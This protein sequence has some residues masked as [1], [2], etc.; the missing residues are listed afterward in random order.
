LSAKPSEK[1]ACT[2]GEAGVSHG[3]TPMQPDKAGGFCSRLQLKS[4]FTDKLL[5]DGTKE[6]GRTWIRTRDLCDVNA[7]L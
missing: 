5:Y 2:E 7:A 6:H 1:A 4:L 3:D